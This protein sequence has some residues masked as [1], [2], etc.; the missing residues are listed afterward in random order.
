MKKSI[1][2]RLLSL[3]LVIC[4]ALPILASCGT[5]NWE[6][7]D[8]NAISLDMR[9]LREDDTTELVIGYGEDIFTSIDKSN[10]KLLAVQQTAADERS[11]DEGLKIKHV[12]ITDF[13]CRVD[14][15]RQM[16]VTLPTSA[17]HL[18]YL[19][20]IHSSAIS[21]GK[22]GEAFAL[23]SEKTDGEIVYSAT[24]DGEYAMGDKNPVITVTL[25]NTVALENIDEKMFTLTGLFSDLK[26][27]GVS[28]SENVIS[29]F[30]E[31]TVPVSSTFAFGVDISKN[32]TK[33]K[34][35]LSAVGEVV[36][37]ASYIKQDSFAYTNGTLTF[38]AVLV[39]DTVSLK[40]GDT[41]SEN[42]LTYK[43]KSVSDD[44][45]T[46]TFAVSLTAENIDAAIEQVNGTVLTLPASKTASAT[47]LK[48]P[49]YAIKASV[50][51]S[52]DY[53]EAA[54]AKDSYKATVIMFVKNGNWN[55]ELTAAD[56]TFAGDFAGATVNSVKKDENSFVVSVTFT[57]EGINLEKLALGGSVTVSAGKACNAWGSAVQNGNAHMSYVTAADKSSLVDDF[58][59]FL[60]SNMDTFKTIKKIGTTIANT[61]G[62]PMSIA[63]SVQTILKLTGVINND[64]APSLS[65]LRDQIADV[66][67]SIVAMDK[68]LDKLGS[69]IT[70]NFADTINAIHL[71]TFHTASA[72]WNNFVTSY[73][74]PVQEMIDA[75]T[76]AYNEYILTFI[77]N[78]HTAKGAVTVYIDKEN[79]VTLPHPLTADYSIDGVKMQK[80]ESYMLKVALTEVIDKIMKN[81]GRLY[82]GYWAD[83][84]NTAGDVI[85]SA[86]TDANVSKTDFLLGV[87]MSA[88]T[89]ALNKVGAENIIKAYTSF[90]TALAG[91]GTSIAM[92]P[93]DS[94]L[95][96]MSIYYNFHKEAKNDI[97][98]TLAW[99]GGI[100]IEYSGLATLAYEFSP[101]AKDGIIEES[102]AA[103]VNKLEDAYKATRKHDNYSYVAGKIVEDYNL[104]I[105]YGRFVL[106]YLKPDGSTAYIDNVLIHYS[107]DIFRPG[108]FLTESHL[109][110][111]AGRYEYLL[112]SGE[113]AS[114][115]FRHYLC[116]LG[117]ADARVLYNED[118]SEK[119]TN[120][121]VSPFTTDTIPLNNTVTLPLVYFGYDGRSNWFKRGDMVTVGTNGKINKKYFHHTNMNTVDVMDFNGNVTR[122]HMMCGRAEYDEQHW[123]WLFGSNIT[124]ETWTLQ[125]VDTTNTML[126]RLVDTPTR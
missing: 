32:A 9:I 47:D 108:T 66:Q 5:N 90:C 71:N 94:Y 48:L 121:I 33:A 43:V 58:V 69:N 109:Q 114:P 41:V 101:T 15:A 34:I 80:A 115:N 19:A 55:G 79:D 8:E 86:G 105:S 3:F 31:G 20:V 75:Y 46:V 68:K 54:D 65:S 88:T 92:K 23:L 30:T 124:M 12:D 26:I 93:L 52:V 87:E 81:G 111:M 42:G 1:G 2:T 35:D 78:G 50:G 110:M 13:T 113:T 51:A 126:F 39:S 95:T 67:N 83:V 103:V 116:S 84:T 118:G 53:V 64:N 62:N 22:F 117:V 27:S 96:M 21:N 76:A 72:N 104:Q 119:P 4:I 40:S 63:K 49:I 57:K 24:V 99:I 98:T 28:A 6:V 74:V 38:D 97:N 25:G 16:T 45:S 10:V 70:S 89:Y 122:N 7:N 44:K 37:R 91:Q 36:Y 29:L 125:Y 107:Q 112:K 85:T 123:Y 18:G 17:D 73:V 82:N 100:L 106:T 11:A 77:T 59:G 14:S 102:Y 120:I 60:S 56:L 61:S